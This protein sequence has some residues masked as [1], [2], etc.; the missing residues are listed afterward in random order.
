[1]AKRCDLCGTVLDEN[2]DLW[3]RMDLDKEICRDC[4]HEGYGTLGRL[5]HRLK[6]AARK[7]RGDTDS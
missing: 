1:M 7:Q 3:E 5:L 4:L 2:D 6:G